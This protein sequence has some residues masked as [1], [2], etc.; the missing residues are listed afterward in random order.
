MAASPT[1]ATVQLRKA[2]GQILD[3]YIIIKSPDGSLLYYKGSFQWWT[4][5][6]KIITELIS[7]IMAKWET[8]GITDWHQFIHT[9]NMTVE[10][11]LVKVHKQADTYLREFF[12]S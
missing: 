7:H 6:D 9:S 8:E 5:D 11:L 12:Q 2:L 10:E 3:T 4:L 1:A